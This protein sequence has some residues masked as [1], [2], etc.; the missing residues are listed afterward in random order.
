M[1]VLRIA[2]PPACRSPQRVEVV[3][4]R[5]LLDAIE[6]RVPRLGNGCEIHRESDDPNP[7]P[8]RRIPDLAFGV[9]VVAGPERG[10]GD[11]PHA[12]GHFGTEVRR[13]EVRIATA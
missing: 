12:D 11:V 7:D 5:P 6:T 8:E 4:E 9:V 1:S 13:E 10:A 2:S 3:P